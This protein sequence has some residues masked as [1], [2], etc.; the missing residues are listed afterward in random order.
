MLRGA[1]G[2]IR[3]PLRLAA[4]PLPDAASLEIA[5]SAA[6]PTGPARRMSDRPFHRQIVKIVF[7]ILRGRSRAHWQD[8]WPHL[9]VIRDETG[10][11]Q[12]L[13]KGRPAGQLLP[14]RL[15]GGLAE[16][17]IV[18]SG[19]SLREQDVSR[20]P[21]HSAIL[22][23]G[24][25]GLAPKCAPLALAVEDE[26]FVWRHRTMLAGAPTDCLWMLSPSVMRALLSEDAST[27][28]GRRI[29]L[30][31]NILKPVHAPRRTADD[32]ALAA[33]LC[34]GADGA[35][36][37]RDPAR[38]IMPA[39]TVAFTA[40]QFAV[41]AR[42]GLVRLAGIDLS[43]AA[44]PRFYETESDMAPSGLVDG[45]GRI[46]AGFALARR[47]AAEAGVTLTCASRV[48]ALLGIGYPLDPLLG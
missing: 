15:P 31:D 1:S 29:I 8:S 25:I 3:G 22:L 43:N 35:G 4:L 11:G 44:A 41:A 17:T 9:R 26:R 36:F 47:C 7:Q 34:R 2:E 18:G 14:A 10:A 32:P 28:A 6:S 42:P 46:L 37:S 23:N 45:L 13:W 16:I 19:P 21:A 12:I 20:L 24:A 38:G 33:I 48:S 5:Y 40:L 30:I 39:G 27:L